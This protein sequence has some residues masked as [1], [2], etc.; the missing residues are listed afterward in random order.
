[1][2]EQPHTKEEGYTFWSYVIMNIVS[3][4]EGFE[5]NDV[6]ATGFLMIIS[7]QCWQTSLSQHQ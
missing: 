5:R 6:S 1:M 4:V 3:T 7:P 2:Q